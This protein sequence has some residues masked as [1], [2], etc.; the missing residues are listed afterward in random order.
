MSLV[1]S[2]RDGNSLRDA[3]LVFSALAFF[4]LFSFGAVFRVD[5]EYILAAR[6]QSLALWGSL[7]Q[8]QVE[9]NLRV[10]ELAAYGDAAMQVEP[11]QAILGAAFYHLG[12]A[13]GGGG[14]QALFVM[15]LLATAATGAVVFATVLR[16]GWGRGAALWCAMLFGLGTMAWPYSTTYYRDVLAMLAASLA[17]L[18]WAQVLKARG[19]GRRLAVSGVVG[20]VAAGMLAKNTCA[21]LILAFGAGVAAAGWQRLRA[22]DIPLRWLLAST[23]VLALGLLGV[24]LIPQRGPL[25]RYSLEYLAFLVGHA[26]GSVGTDLLLAVSGPFLSPSRSVFL[27]S[28]PLILS[29]LSV[30]RAWRAEWRFTLP[31]LFFPLSLALLQGLFYRGLWGGVYGW[32]LRFMLPSLPGLIVL[33]APRVEAMV[34]KG[35]AA[36]RWGLWFSLISGG[37][38]QAAGAWVPWIDSYREWTAQGLAPYSPASA[39]NARFLVIPAQI[40][41]LLDPRMWDLAWLRLWREG[42][43]RAA[44]LAFL[45][46]ALAAVS[47]ALLL[48]EPKAIRR[49]WLHGLVC[50]LLVSSLILPLRPNL[51]LVRSDPAWGGDRPEFD[52]ALQWLRSRATAGDCLLLDSYATSLWFFWMNRWDRPVRWT[53]LPF[54][55]PGASV[56]DVG[57]TARDLLAG[58]ACAQGRVRY[59]VSTDSPTHALRR[60]DEHSAVLEDFVE[61]VAFGQS[62]RVEIWAFSPPGWWPQGGRDQRVGLSPPCSPGEGR[63]IGS[64]TTRRERGDCPHSQ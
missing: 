57:E 30:R 24:S 20:A 23:G 37:V 42:D 39:W 17:F 27:F 34:R 16:L 2:D 4:Y 33:C 12:M 14:A 6:A 7:E 1:E 38:V 53:S 11:G 62:S 32:G 3:V 8:P 61:A 51:S 59:I 64:Q 49:R 36:P 47:L 22:G 19:T 43:P 63:R 55:L 29:F 44:V 15:N 40:L 45:A 28:P 5:D 13:A 58:A 56:S 52:Q 35:A 46:L 50:A 54:E 41:R 21:A 26:R 48:P 10:Q 18:T 60:T 25:A 31:V 9:G